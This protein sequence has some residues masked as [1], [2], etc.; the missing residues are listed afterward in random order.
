VPAQGEPS[1]F[2][3]AAAGVPIHSLSGRERHER[4]N[5]GHAISFLIHLN[6][7]Y[8]VVRYYGANAGSILAGAIYIP[9]YAPRFQRSSI[10]TL[11]SFRRHSASRITGCVL[12][13][14]LLPSNR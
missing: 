11:Q 6:H 1:L 7:A 13:S 2:G 14:A 9:R 12:C 3:V 5:R 10:A 8:P 4:T